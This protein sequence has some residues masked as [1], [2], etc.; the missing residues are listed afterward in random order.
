[1]ADEVL[2]FVTLFTLVE[3]LL[4]HY[5]IQMFELMIK[6]QKNILLSGINSSI[7]IGSP[8]TGHV[9][10][11]A[12]CFSIKDFSKTCPFRET[13]GSIGSTPDTKE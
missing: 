1:V 13:T 9:G 5:L 11:E 10:F 6:K 7:L 8:V 3:G 4:C 12:K 2:G